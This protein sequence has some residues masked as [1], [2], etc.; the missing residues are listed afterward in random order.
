[1]KKITLF[2]FS[3]LLIIILNNH[4]SNAQAYQDGDINVGAAIGIASRLVGNSGLPIAI[5][6]EKGFHEAI[7]AGLYVSYASYNYSFWKYTYFIAGI[8]GAYHFASVIDIPDELDLYGG[9]MLFYQN[10]TVKEREITGFS[11][12]SPGSVGLG[13]YV[14]GRYYFTDNVAGFLEIGTGIAI[15]QLGATLKFGG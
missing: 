10:V 7:S 3:F 2:L 6:A 4:D 9:A 5:H 8:R 15:L 1:M 12:S 14:G 13:I 11:A